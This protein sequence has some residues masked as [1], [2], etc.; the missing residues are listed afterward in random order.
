MPMGQQACN[1]LGWR[2]GVLPGQGRR[3]CMACRMQSK[4]WCAWQRRGW[5]LG[6]QRLQHG[7]S[8]S[9]CVVQATGSGSPDYR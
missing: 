4:Q 1:G 9:L 6:V 5:R 8:N 7:N 2:R 3:D